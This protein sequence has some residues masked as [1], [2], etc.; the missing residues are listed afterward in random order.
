M[1]DELVEVVGDQGTLDSR[2]LGGVEAAQRASAAGDQLVQPAPR[3][4]GE[5]P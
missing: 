1:R 2:C 4:V 5:Q 3:R